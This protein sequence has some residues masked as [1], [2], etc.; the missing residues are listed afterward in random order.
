M[1]KGNER[2]VE[3]VEFFRE[4]IALWILALRNDQSASRIRQVF[5]EPVDRMVES[6]R[7]SKAEARNLDRGIERFLEL[8]P[9]EDKAAIRTR[10]KEKYGYDRIGV[11]PRRV[12]Q[13]VLKR[14]RVVGD[15]EAEIVRDFVGNL[16]NQD[17][18]GKRNFM[19]LAELLD[20]AGY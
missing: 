4:K 19:R 1:N 17:A 2:F 6:G 11:E 13:R 3:Q 18:I 7:I 14:G 12:V 15:M 5:L 9:A 16:T 20:R 10:L 8:L